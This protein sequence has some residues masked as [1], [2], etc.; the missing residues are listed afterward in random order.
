MVKDVIATFTRRS[1]GQ[2]VT[3]RMVKHHL[4]LSLCALVVEGWLQHSA[5]MQQMQ[6]PCTKSCR[7]VKA[8]EL[9]ENT[10]GNG[11]MGRLLLLVGKDDL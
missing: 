4:F 5:A 7:A 3:V 9:R 10:V 1:L 6:K 2:D 8:L 11:D